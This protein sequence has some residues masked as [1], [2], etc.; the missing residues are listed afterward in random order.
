MKVFV[1]YVDFHWDNYQGGSG[2]SIDARVVVDIHESLLVR[3]VYGF[4][5][6]A[7]LDHVLKRRP[8]NQ[9]NRHTIVLME[10]V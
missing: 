7:V 2:H 8:F 3:D 6:N 1:S 9:T 10:L 5:H 4:V